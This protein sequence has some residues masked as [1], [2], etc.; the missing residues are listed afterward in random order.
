M[1]NPKPLT[2]S[3]G[4]VRELIQED[5]QRGMNFSELSKNLQI[6][7]NKTETNLSHPTHL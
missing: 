2:N 3:E 5:F 1:E 4:K 7:L 6:K